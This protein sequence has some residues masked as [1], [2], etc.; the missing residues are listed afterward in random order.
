MAR[1]NIFYIKRQGLSHIRTFKHHTCIFI[2]EQNNTHSYI[3][4][5]LLN[6]IQQQMQIYKMFSCHV[7]N[8]AHLMQLVT[9]SILAEC[10]DPQESRHTLY[11]ILMEHYTGDTLFTLPC[12]MTE[13][14]ITDLN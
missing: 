4:I 2:Q 13:T 6:N 12:S 11:I 3:H 8:T 9:Q 7:P 5:E 14:N 1:Q 10:N